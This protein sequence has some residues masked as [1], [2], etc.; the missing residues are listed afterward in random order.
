MYDAII[1]NGLVA[2]G[3]SPQL[4][5]M[6]VAVKGDKIS[7]IAPDISRGA[8]VVVNAEGL[9]VAPGFVDIHS[10]SD[11]YL[12]IDPRARSKVLQGVTTE[13]GG[14]CGYSAAPMGG[15]VLARRAKDYEEQF[16]VRVDW[17]NMDEYFE[18]LD[19]ARPAVNYGALI[20]YN[21]V[22]GSVLGFN[23]SKPGPERMTEIQKTVAQALDHGALGMS[24][25]VVYPPACFA[26]TAE[27]IEAFRPVAERGKVFTSHIRSEGP[28]LLESLEE[29]TA[30]AKGSGAKLQV[31][32]LKTAGKDNW[33][34]LDKAFGILEGAMAEGV[35][36]MADRYP[37]LASN[38]GLQVILP[39]RAFDGG[40]D[41][42]VAMLGDKRERASFREEILRNHPEPE[43]WQT[44]MVSQVVTE[45]NKDIEGLTVAE[46]AVKRGKEP[47][48]FVFDL[49]LEEKTDVEAIYFCM[50]EDNLSRILGK[51]WVVVGSDAGARAVDGPLALGKPHPRTFGSFPRFFR[52]YVFE[53]K[54][55]SIPEAVRKTSAQACEFFGIAGRGK[56][57]EGYF[58]DIV[59][60]N[61]E[62]IGDNSTYSQPL[63]YPSGIAHVMVNGVFAVL[64]GAPTERRPG[65][66]ITA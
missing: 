45:K 22:R 38:T 21:T 11:Y 51:P 34:K 65:R 5:K 63:A 33:R 48:E 57:K 1:K 4:K 7:A 15:E 19:R 14:N 17:A 49:L 13:V 35:Q 6:D 28:R 53:K 8:D 41:N 64:D 56:L 60:F 61:P 26:E 30:I 58:A 24:V 29:V 32:H 12:I 55:V 47:L 16:G 39:D 54:L 36:I 43:Y 18:S 20:G 62:T 27:F 9:V 2:D 52:E 40:K 50:S 31:S 66:V 25:G 42:L 59:A 46:G 3:E 23:S 37:Y 10:H 44:V